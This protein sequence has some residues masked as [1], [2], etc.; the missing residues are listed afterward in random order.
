MSDYKTIL[1]QCRKRD[2]RAQLEFYMLFYKSVYNSAY[3]ILGNSQEAEE[4][5]QETFLKVFDRIEDYNGEASNMERI[6]KRIAINQAIDLCRKRK[7]QF[8]S[9]EENVYA[10]AEENSEDETDIQLQLIAEKLKQLPEGYRLMINLHLIE[11]L[12][13][14]EIAQMLQLSPSTV[15][16]QFARARNKLI[17]LIKAHSTYESLSR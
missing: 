5:M 3:R 12:K 17:R 4:V 14:E 1:R 6:L 15:R 2:R 9:L 13:Y 8:L 11:G 7:V 16:S 10:M